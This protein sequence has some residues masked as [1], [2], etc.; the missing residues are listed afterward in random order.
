MISSAVGMLAS[1]APRVPVNAMPIRPSGR[2]AAL[3]IRRRREPLL[4]PGAIA[5]YQAA[6]AA[7]AMMS[8][9]PSV[10][11]PRALIREWHTGHLGPGEVRYLRTMLPLVM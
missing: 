1:V 3:T 6:G 9:I 8:A 11:K 10:W 5:R 7:I 4:R 2:Y